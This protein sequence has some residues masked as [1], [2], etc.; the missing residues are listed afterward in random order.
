MSKVQVGVAR[1][2]TKHR[3]WH[4]GE[5]RIVEVK[6][7]KFEQVA[8]ICTKCNSRLATITHMGPFELTIE[9]KP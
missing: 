2:V 7:E 6:S 1:K 9:S 3:W 4:W 8:Y 5:R